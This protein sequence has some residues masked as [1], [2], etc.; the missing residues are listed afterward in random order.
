MFLS[1]EV[2]KLKTPPVPL[3]YPQGQEVIQALQAS[4]LFSAAQ[5]KKQTHPNPHPTPLPP[6]LGA[7]TPTSKNSFSEDWPFISFSRVQPG[8]QKQ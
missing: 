6:V 3:F 8:Y 5:T 7:A 4:A 1:G 2:G